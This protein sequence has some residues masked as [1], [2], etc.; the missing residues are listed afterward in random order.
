MCM[1]L[2]RQEVESFGDREIIRIN[3][4]DIMFLSK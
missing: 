1:M 2:V 3:G 4:S